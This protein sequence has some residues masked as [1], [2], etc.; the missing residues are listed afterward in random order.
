VKLNQ[1]SSFAVLCVCFLVSIASRSH[2]DTEDA[3]AVFGPAVAPVIVTPNMDLSAQD[4]RG[5][6]FV[7]QDLSK[8]IFDRAS[9]AGARILD[10]DLSHA[11]FKGADL[12]GL[13]IGECNVDDADFTDATINRIQSATNVAGPQELF[14]AHDL[15]LSTTQW[16]STRSYAAKDLSYC[17]IPGPNKPEPIDFSGFN[18]QETYLLQGDFTACSFT[19]ARIHGTKFSG[20]KCTMKQ[21]RPTRD[22]VSER[23]TCAFGA[24]TGF[25]FSNLNLH[26]SEITA[27]PGSR[28]DGCEIRACTLR[29]LGTSPK[30]LIYSTKSYRTGWLTDVRFVAA[31]LSGISFDRIDLTGCRFDHCDLSNATFEDAV[32]TG[33][34]FEFVRKGSLTLDQLKGTWNFQHDRMDRVILP[35]RWR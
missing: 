23:F 1:Q 30:E 24:T 6:E 10:C 9:L 34:S 28:L 17:V 32:I 5:C 33:V 27:M 29:F 18:L 22:F 15:L 13:R 21:L 2:A 4:L 19:D 12:S 3:I 11:S 8:A 20:C 7:G 25:D 16:I 14:R 35:A 31:D 26:G